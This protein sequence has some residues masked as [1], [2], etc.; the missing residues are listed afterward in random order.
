MQHISKYHS[1][2]GFFTG[3]AKIFFYLLKGRCSFTFVFVIFLVY[4]QD[5]TKPAEPICTKHSEGIG[6]GQERNPLNCGADPVKGADPGNHF[7][8]CNIIEI[9]H[10]FC[11]YVASADLCTLLSKIL[12][13]P[14]VIIDTVIGPLRSDMIRPLTCII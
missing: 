11:Q 9:F 4:H 1:V 2:P 3:R 6:H 13:V 7:F 8:L 10:H 5:Y 12:A 14:A